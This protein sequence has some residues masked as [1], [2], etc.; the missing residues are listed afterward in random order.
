[1][2]GAMGGMVQGDNRP[3][4]WPKFAVGAALI[5]PSCAAGEGRTPVACAL[6]AV[7]EARVSAAFAASGQCV[8]PR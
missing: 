2:G 5:T 1:M 4:H 3:P 8:A 6:N 7:G